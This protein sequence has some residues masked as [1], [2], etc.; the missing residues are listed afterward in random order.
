M[1]PFLFPIIMMLY[2]E[3]SSDKLTRFCARNTLYMYCMALLVSLYLPVQSL[4]LLFVLG[5][6]MVGYS[7]LFWKVKFWRV[8]VLFIISLFL[9][10]V[11]YLS[12]YYVSYEWFY[13]IP[14][15]MEY[16]NIILR[17]LSVIAVS[18]CC[19]DKGTDIKLKVGVLGAYLIEY[20]YLV[21]I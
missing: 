7:F 19:I 2:S 10:I 21:G 8:R 13:T 4:T 1:T 16:S 11:N 20:S 3:K 6:Y 9:Q 18:M 17:E 12:L 5:V 14:Y 15:Y